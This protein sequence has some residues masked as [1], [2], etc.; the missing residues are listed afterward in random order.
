ML[1]MPDS[2][3]LEQTTRTV[4]G[5]QLDRPM[6]EE[7]ATVFHMADGGWGALLSL[8]I[9]PMPNSIGLRLERGSLHQRVTWLMA[10]VVLFPVI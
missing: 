9:V 5:S 6:E 7:S 2:P 8:S 3:P 4:D 1:A 10:A